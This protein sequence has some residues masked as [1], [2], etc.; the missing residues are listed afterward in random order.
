MLADQSDASKL[1][2]AGYLDHRILHRWIAEIIP[3][4]LRMN[5]QQRFQWVGKPAALA[6]C[7]G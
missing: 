2:H 3:L 6:A 7:L 5:P 4:M 1:A